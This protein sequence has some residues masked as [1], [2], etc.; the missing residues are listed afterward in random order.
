MEL[1]ALQPSGA[2]INAAD[3]RGFFG[4]LKGLLVHARSFSD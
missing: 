4:R 1:D 2:L 3:Y